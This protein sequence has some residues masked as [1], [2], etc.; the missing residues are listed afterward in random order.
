MVIS[1]NKVR[2]FKYVISYSI[3]F[4][5]R[6]ATLTS[7]STCLSAAS[8]SSFRIAM[9]PKHLRTPTHTHTGIWKRGQNPSPS[10]HY[11]NPYLFTSDPAITNVCSKLQSWQVHHGR[12]RMI[13]ASGCR[14]GEWPLELIVSS[15]RNLAGSLCR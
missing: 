8:I 7:S 14:V 12:L 11:I 6:T 9:I 5:L 2:K 10:G 15:E 4:N 13:H 1:A 3:K